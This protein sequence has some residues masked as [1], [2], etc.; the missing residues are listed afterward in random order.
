MHQ[1]NFT[2]LAIIGQTETDTFITREFK[3]ALIKQY[4]E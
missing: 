3:A 4:I 1:N 2:K